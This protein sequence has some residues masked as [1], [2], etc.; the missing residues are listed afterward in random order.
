MGGWSGNP[1]QVTVPGNY[2]CC[3]KAGHYVWDCTESNM[4]W[5]PPPDVTEDTAT[6][7]HRKKGAKSGVTMSYCSVFKR[8]D[9]HNAPGHDAC[10]ATQGGSSCTGVHAAAAVD[11]VESGEDLDDDFIPF[12][13]WPISQMFCYVIGYPVRWGLVCL[14][15]SLATLL[16]GFLV[17][18]EMVM[19]IIALQELYKSLIYFGF[20]SINVTFNQLTRLKH[21]LT[22]IGALV[23]YYHFSD[24]WIALYEST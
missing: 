5:D 7:D 10:Q 8:W 1:K 13:V 15:N 14:F 18:R 4:Y 11:D 19:N 16:L 12:I 17:K 23:Y 3:G 9:Y 2:N 6:E 24:Q 20:I 21:Y 22:Y